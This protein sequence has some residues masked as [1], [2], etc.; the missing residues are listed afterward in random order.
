MIDE[1]RTTAPRTRVFVSSVIV[2]FEEFR[3]AAREG[4]TQA[5]G[6]PILVN[7]DFPALANSARSV[8]LDAVASSDFLVTI[9]GARGGW[10]APSGKLVVEEELEEAERRKIPVLLFE[11][12]GVSRDEDAARFARRASHFVSGTFRRT[13]RTPDELRQ[14]L[15]ISLAPHLAS[16][17]RRPMSR[18]R[19]DHFAS[20]HRVS[21]TTMLRFVLTPERD[22]E[23]IDP[24]QLASAEFGRRVLELGHARG[25]ELFVYEEPKTSKVEREAL[26]IEQ[27]A[28]GGRHGEGEHV[29]FQLFEAGALVIDVNVTG[30]RKER[31]RFDMQDSPIVDIDDVEAVTRRCFA[32]GRALY[33]EID[34]FRRHQTFLFNAALTGLGHRTLERNPQPRH[35]YPMSMRSEHQIIVAH[36]QPRR[37]NRND[38]AAPSAEIDRAILRFVQ[39]AGD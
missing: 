1:G 2:G 15:M 12:E 18:P 34:P 9:V 31:S 19:I 16:S 14:E 30:R 24:V 26:V 25:V 11:Q 39:A 21:S 6:E 22:E 37:V 32:M 5:G 29:L 7:E 3:A 33:D 17:H 28:S 27:R 13:F 36:E 20:P 4:I 8:C 23:V 10:T 38:L 35:I